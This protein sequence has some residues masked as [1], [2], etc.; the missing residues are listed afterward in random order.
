MHHVRIYALVGIVLTLPFV[1]GNLIVSHH[2][3]PWDSYIQAAPGVL[4][5]VLTLMLVGAVVAGWPLW[6]QR[7]WYWLNGIISIIIALISMIVIGAFT[8]EFIRCDLRML[9]NCD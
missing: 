7:Q 6:H 2:V 5:L 9:P 8:D 4:W 1:L 3:T